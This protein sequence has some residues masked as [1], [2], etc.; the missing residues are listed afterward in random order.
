M[1]G[2]DFMEETISGLM[3]K[4]VV[5]LCDGKILGYASDFKVDIFTG[6]LTALIISGEGGF[7]RLKKCSDIVIPW[8]KICKIGKDTIIVDIGVLAEKEKETQKKRCLFN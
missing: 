6:N 2:V 7:F 4:Q 1:K 8:C 5:N 3:E